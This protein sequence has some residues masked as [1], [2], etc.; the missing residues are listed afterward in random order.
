MDIQYHVTGTVQVTSFQGGK[1]EAFHINVIVSAESEVEAMT[2]AAHDLMRGTDYQRFVWQQL[3]I[4]PVEGK[5]V[6]AEVKSGEQPVWR[7]AAKV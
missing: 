7:L 5:G 3:S 4:K 6:G 2:V 1:T